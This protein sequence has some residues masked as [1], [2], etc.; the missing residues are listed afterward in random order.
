MGRGCD[1]CLGS[2]NVL[3]RSALPAG[4]ISSLGFSQ[5]RPLGASLFPQ[6][7]EPGGTECQ[8]CER[9]TG[10]GGVVLTGKEHGVFFACSQYVALESLRECTGDVLRRRVRLS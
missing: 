8:R 4:C 3:G 5:L 10:G 7:V 1:R 9:N 6:S 2:P